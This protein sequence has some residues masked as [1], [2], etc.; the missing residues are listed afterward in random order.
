M[1][2]QRDSMVSKLILDLDDAD[3]GLCNAEYLELTSAPD[4]SS[5]PDLHET[6][7]GSEDGVVVP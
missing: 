6:N 5:T 7:R 1:R 3:G 2:C 4:S